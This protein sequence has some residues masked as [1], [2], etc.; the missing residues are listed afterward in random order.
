MVENDDWFEPYRIGVPMIDA[1]HYSLFLEVRKFGKEMRVGLSHQ[2]LEEAL[3]F[4]YTYVGTHFVR[5]EQ[6]MREKN[7]PHFLEHKTLHHELKKVVFAVQK[8]FQTN[9]DLVD[10]DKLHTFLNEW[11]QEH[12]LKVDVALASYMSGDVTGLQQG[13]E[14]QMHVTL[15]S[16]QPLVEVT[17]KVPKDKLQVIE[18]CAYVL[19]HATPEAQDLEELATSATGM[20][21]EEAMQLAAD[22]L[23]NKDD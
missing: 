4:L 9:P 1:D 10:C 23:N 18:R 2:Q 14:A 5:E 20:S 16:D 13:A 8:V 6:L 21:M 19:Q 11:L 3:S 12:I 7:Y 15:S 17:V 22:V